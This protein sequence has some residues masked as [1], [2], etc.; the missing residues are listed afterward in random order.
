MNQKLKTATFLFLMLILLAPVFQQKY[1]LFKLKSLDG[2][3]NPAVYPRFSVKSWFADKFQVQFTRATEEHLGFRPALIR[4]KNQLEYIIYNKANASGVVVGKHRYLF[5]SDYIRSYT[6]RDYL[7]DYYWNQKFNRLKQVSDTLAKLGVKIAIILEPGKATYH[8]EMIPSRFM[9][10]KSE[11]TNY[12][13]IIR[14]SD[15]NGIPLLDL[16][17]LFKDKKS[18][19]PYP[20]Y[21]KGG[22]HWSN[23]GM[24][25]AADT[26]LGF[27]NGTLHLT[28]PDLI[29]DRVELSDSLRDT[30]SDV[31]NVMNLM[32][33]PR[34]PKMAY[35]VFHFAAKDSIRKPRVL[36]ISDSYYF[37]V[38]EAKIPAGAFANEAFWYYNNNI[39]P[40]SWK[41]PKDTGSLN[42]PETVEGMDLVLIMVTERFYHRF[43]W[44]FTDVLYRYYYPD[45]IMEYRYDFMRE[46]VRYFT[47]FDD[48]QQQAD[49]S[50]TLMQE[51]LTAHADYLFW[52]ADQAGKIPHDAGYFRMNILKDTLWMKQIREKALINKISV[53]EQIS[54]D[55]IWMLQQKNQ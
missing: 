49:Y 9:R 26:L 34:H 2:Q 27:I 4:L 52:Q 11:N 13:A 30:D 37:N 55:A 12:Q 46:I 10:F 53:D 19:A 44:D 48:I 42:V 7:G 32:M 39:Y 50:G 29:I 17:R 33:A 3:A 24:V 41:A 8:P 54:K 35:P 16:N 1:G 6:G 36:V 5:E 15:Q 14:E 40:D 45:A 38:L 25:L 18:S 22:T 28:V 21:P 23:G 31:V 47:L 20:L 51:K 43:D